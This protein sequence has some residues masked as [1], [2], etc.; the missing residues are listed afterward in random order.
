MTTLNPIT[1]RTLA[2]RLHEQRCVPFLGAGVA[3]HL[4]PTGQCLAQSWIREFDLPLPWTSPL[5]YV[6]QMVAVE[7]D[8]MQPKEF[9]ARQISQAPAYQPGATNDPYARIADL[10][11]PIY[12]TTNYDNY[13][14]RA[15]EA[16]GRK[17]V[18][19]L[20]PWNYDLRQQIGDEE[21]LARPSYDTPWVYHL[22]GHYK[23]PESLVLTEDDYTDFLVNMAGPRVSEG[24]PLHHLISRQ[25]YNSAL[26]FL[27][28]SLRDSTF[29]V[30]LRGLMSPREET[31]RRKDITVQLRQRPAFEGGSQ[32]LDEEVSEFFQLNERYFER[33]R[34]GVYWGDVNKFLEDL[35]KYFKRAP[36]DPAR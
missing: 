31:I 10:P 29:R 5:Q 17:P 24:D 28:Y 18:T 8:P 36:A 11:V 2:D 19:V 34:L 35:D 30:L 16:A 12:I 9:L 26:L 32:A 13:L 1:W 4:F 15:L 20:C 3:A 33:M 7:S 21:E 27:G 25:L 14:Q 6:A 22:H 23:K